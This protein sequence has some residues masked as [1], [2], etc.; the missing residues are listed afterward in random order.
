HPH[1]PHLRP[2]GLSRLLPGR[3]TVTGPPVPPGGR[4]P[5]RPTG[6]VPPTPLFVAAGWSPHPAVISALVDAGAD[7]AAR[8]WGDLTP[9]HEAASQNTNAGVTAALLEAGVDPN[10]RD[11]DGIVPILLAATDNSNPDVVT[12]LVEAGADPNARDPYGNTPLHLAW[13]TGWFD[14]RP[15][16]RELLRLGADPLVRNDAGQIADQT[17]CDNWNTG[18]FPYLALPADYLRCLDAGAD[19]NARDGERQM[20][21]HRALENQ[22]LEVTNLLLDA[23]ADPNAANSFGN[24][25]LMQALWLRSYNNPD[26]ESIATGLVRLLLAAGADANEHT[27]FGLTPLYSAASQ[28]AAE[29]VGV[30][31]EAGAD[32]NAGDRSPLEAAVGEGAVASVR[33]LLAAGA[34]PNRPGWQGELP[35]AAA[36]RS[37]DTEV[38]GLL[39][40]AGAEVDTRTGDS[41]AVREQKTPGG[42]TLPEDPDYPCRDTDFLE[43]APPESLRA[44]LDADARFD[45]PVARYDLTPI[46]FLA[47]MGGAAVPEKIALLLAAGADPNTVDDYGRTAL[48]LLVSRG[49]GDGAVERI[50]VPALIDAGADVHARDD[51]GRTALHD[52]VE[53]AVRRGQPGQDASHVIQLLLRAGADVNAHTHLGESPLRMAWVPPRDATVVDSVISVLLEAGAEIGARTNDGRTPLHVGVQGHKPAAV[54]ALLEARADPALRDDAGNLADPT[55][56]EH[57]GKAV[58]FA[59]ADAD[60]IARCLEAGADPVLPVEGDARDRGSLL[61]VAS[62]HARD[63]TVITAL[64]EAGADVHARD[65]WGFTPLHSAAEN[66]TPAA[67][68]ALVQAGADVNAPRRSFGRGL[69]S[70]GG[71]TPLHFA[72]SN[73]NPEVAA[74]LIEAGAEVGAR[75][76]IRGGTPLHFAVRNPNPEVAALLLDAGANVNAREFAQTYLPYGMTVSGVDETTRRLGGVTP[77]HEAAWPNP[78]PEVIHVLLEAGADPSALAWRTEDHHRAERRSDNPHYQWSGNVTPLYDAARFSA[79]PE[80]VAT[81]VGA[82]ADLEGRGAQLTFNPRQQT[83]TPRPHLSPLYLAV[84]GDGH[85]ATI[86][87]LVRAGANL[88]L[89]DSDGRT[90]LHVAAIGYPAVFP[91]LLR[92]GADPDALDADGKTPMDYARENYMLQQWERVGMSGPLDKR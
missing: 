59:T 38:I 56:C 90:V 11:R 84:R 18:Y 51:R 68:Q 16:M 55:A 5:R 37:G 39:E 10:A 49:S 27:R 66:P 80:V 13:N 64:V 43:F 87:A 14:Y 4:G 63:P 83:T 32:P 8:Y 22:D 61:R 44:C 72:A 1:P 36:I 57:W 46:S 29:L 12:L 42:E 78:N 34:D 17:H 30:L 60:A 71:R 69:D 23:G 20:L 91:L 24:S 35:L 65:V 62:A 50:S 53:A 33:V 15:V 54:L 77:L 28:G 31:L 25:P 19:P 88:E 82:G 79:D 26:A 3:Y 6:R 75:E 81:L 41:A 86:E 40:A 85:P 67:V 47:R 58:F 74:A 45:E 76:G 48:H 9:L 52:A 70:R 2:L 7:V 21:L 73:P 92:L 89:T